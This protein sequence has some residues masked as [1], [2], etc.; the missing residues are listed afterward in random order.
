MR[1]PEVMMAPSYYSNFGMGKQA[2]I[3]INQSVT[4]EG[5]SMEGVYS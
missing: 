5:C 3:P 1:S 2:P 4:G